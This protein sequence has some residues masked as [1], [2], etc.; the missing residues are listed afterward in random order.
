MLVVAAAVA[1][2]WSNSPWADG[3]E[4]LWLTPVDLAIGAVG[5]AGDLRHL[6]NDGLM[7][8]FFFVVGLEIKRELVTGELRRW[9]TAA[10]P[11]VAAV[12]G[13]VV[14]AL[15]NLSQWWRPAA[16]G[17]AAGGSPWP[18]TSPSQ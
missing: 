17:G 7:T 9:R 12:G 18:P 16:S 10:L 5:F 14:P 15:I 6:V 1:L 3:Y 13:M 11:A 4:H 8:L 2:V